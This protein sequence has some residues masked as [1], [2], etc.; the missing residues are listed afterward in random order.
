[1]P[2]Q[3][4]DRIPQAWTQDAILALVVPTIRRLIQRAGIGDLGG[5]PIDHGS[6]GGLP[7]DDHVQYL[8]DLASTG[9]DGIDVVSRVIEVDLTSDSGLA[10]SFGALFVT[11]RMFNPIN[12]SVDQSKTNDA[13][14]ADD[15]ELVQTLKVNKDYFV[16]MTITFT[17]PSANPDI[18]W[19]FTAPAGAI[20]DLVVVIFRTGTGQRVENQFI[21]EVSGAVNVQPIV[22]GVIYT[23]RVTGVVTTVAASGSLAF[24]WAQ[25]IADVI[26]ATTVRKGSSMRVIEGE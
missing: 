16:D 12:K 8:I 18:K 19:A 5:D 7:D 14:L 1:M 13:T 24:Q 6:L 22:A 4:G 10:F 11:P 26:F 3:P 23:M 17:S 25:N 15:S 9:G 2:Q 21:Y 20:L